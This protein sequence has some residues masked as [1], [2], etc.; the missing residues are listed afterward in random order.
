MR[1][2]ADF[3]LRPREARPKGGGGGRELARRARLGEREAPTER[4]RRACAVARPTIRGSGP[5]KRAKNH[6]R[7]PAVEV[8]QAQERLAELEVRENRVAPRAAATL[9]AS[10]APRRCCLP[11]LRR[12]APFGRPREQSPRLRGVGPD[13]GRVPRAEQWNLVLEDKGALRLLRRPAPRALGPAGLASLRQRVLAGRAQPVAARRRRR[14]LGR[15]AD[16]AARRP[17]R[18]AP[19][20]VGGPVGLLA[21][22]AAVGALAAAAAVLRLAGRVA[23]VARFQWRLLRELGAAPRL[24]G[25][26][27]RLG[28]LEGHG[29]STLSPDHKR[30]E[31]IAL[32]Q[33]C[34]SLYFNMLL[35]E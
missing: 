14:G 15:R 16:G 20:L 23:D 31:P 13:D 7:R 35:S 22:D 26:F 11:G 4:R 21:G 30:Q 12:A 24:Q 8:A 28:G 6:T 1:G 19:G 2:V 3:E 10:V 25:G 17:L 18:L 5:K 32:R 27:E 9:E 34:S 33:K 29:V